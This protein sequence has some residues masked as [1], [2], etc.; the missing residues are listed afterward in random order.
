MFSGYIKIP[1]TSS[2]WILS[3]KE[4]KLIKKSRW[5]VL[6][7]VHGSNFCFIYDIKT[8]TM[9]YA[10]RKEILS[11]DETFFGYKSILKETLPKI[12]KIVQSVVLRK[13]DPNSK[14]CIY[15]ELFG[16]LYPH[17]NVEKNLS[18]SPVQTGIYYSPN[19]HFYAFDISILEADDEQY[20]DYDISLS[21]FKNS[22]ILYAEP[23]LIGSYEEAIEFKINF[24]TTIPNKLKLEPIE[25][26]QAE[27]IIIKPMKEIRINNGKDRAIIKKK[28]LEFSESKYHD[29]EKPK[30]TTDFDYYDY[31]LKYEIDNF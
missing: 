5:C 26:N 30:K 19:L 16:G 11:K 25:N 18:I 2:Q 6:E 20:M 12:E 7:K 17:K 24:I 27:G 4:A 21:I 29:V 22:G 9:E 15:G 1:E 3:P 31:F 10:K 28:I 14:I 13:P 8:K 23:L